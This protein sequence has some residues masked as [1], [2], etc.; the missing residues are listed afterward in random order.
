MSKEPSSFLPLSNLSFHVLLALTSGPAHGYGIGKTIEIR[1][2]GRL[3]PTTGSLYQTLKRL[4]DA[5]LIESAPDAAEESPDQRRVYFRLTA[6]GRRVAAA[7]AR[8]LE[9]LVALAR[10]GRLLGEVS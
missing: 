9:D 5:G 2:H 10:Q 7:E 6:L 4:T 3:N 8:R 1:S